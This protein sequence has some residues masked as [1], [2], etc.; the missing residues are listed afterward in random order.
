VGDLD[1]AYDTLDLAAEPGVAMTIY[2]AEPGSPTQEAL[3]LL[4]SWAATQPAVRQGYEQTASAAPSA[5]PADTTW[6]GP[7]RH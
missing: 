4:A 6:A 7:E 3:Q 2:T 5:E 1:L